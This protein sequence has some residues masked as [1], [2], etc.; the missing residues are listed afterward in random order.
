[1]HSTHTISRK[2]GTK[3]TTH[4]KII[5]DNRFNNYDEVVRRIKMIPCY[6]LSAFLHEIIYPL[7]GKIDLGKKLRT[8]S[9]VT[10]ICK[11]S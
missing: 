6:A 5:K 7:V 11:C 9:A 10:S 1:V 8:F 4:V 3:N 2:Q